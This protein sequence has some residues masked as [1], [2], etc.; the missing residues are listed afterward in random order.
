MSRFA[1]TVD[2]FR[3][4]VE[5]PRDGLI[6]LTDDLLKLCAEE[7]LQLDWQDESCQIHSLDSGAEARVEKPLSPS[8]FRAL[9]ARL[10]ALCQEHRANSVTPYGGSGELHLLGH[11]AVVFRVS[12]ANTA[13]T[14]WLRL[15]PL[16]PLLPPP[17][18]GMPA[19]A[20][21]TARTGN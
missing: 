11:P 19:T 10:A 18:I 16:P 15:S 4:V 17:A 8:V 14:R 1:A 5:H 7:R 9:L 13:D 21:S 20:E 6:G 3:H 2:A 12:F